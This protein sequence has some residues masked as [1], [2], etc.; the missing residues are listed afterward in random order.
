V[1]A[2]P[3]LMSP[4]LHFG[5]MS[6]F[7]PTALPAEFVK[8][9]CVARITAAVTFSSVSSSRTF[10]GIPRSSASR[11]RHSPAKRSTENIKHS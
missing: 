4:I 10:V 11:P 7:E 3:L 5:E 8:K 6:G 9:I 1:L 2:T